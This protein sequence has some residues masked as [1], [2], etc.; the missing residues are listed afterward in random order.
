MNAAK[1]ALPPRVLGFHESLLYAMMHLAIHDALNAIKRRFQ[2][3]GL[4]IKGRQGR[5]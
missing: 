5:L 1:A 3:Y 2:P 4:D